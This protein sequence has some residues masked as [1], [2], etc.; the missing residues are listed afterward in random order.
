MFQTTILCVDVDFIHLTG[1]FCHLVIPDL[2]VLLIFLKVPLLESC[3]Q[4]AVRLT[5]YVLFGHT[6]A[7]PGFQ[8]SMSQFPVANTLM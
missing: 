3:T 6:S 2:Q 1:V 8:Q 4:L 5:P 7:I